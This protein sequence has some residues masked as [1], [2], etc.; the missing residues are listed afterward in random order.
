MKQ[1]FSSSL[2]ETCDLNTVVFALQFYSFIITKTVCIPS[3]RP[4]KNQKTEDQIKTARAVVPCFQLFGLLKNTLHSNYFVVVVVVVVD[5]DVD[6]EAVR[7]AV[8]QKNVCI[9]LI[10][11]FIR[12]ELKV[13]FTKGYYYNYMKN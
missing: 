10:R 12:L 7:T 9:R 13:R 8:Q 4:L 5:D 3:A 1:N 2:I 11:T 6:D